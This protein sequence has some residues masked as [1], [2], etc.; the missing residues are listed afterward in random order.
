MKNKMIS[1]TAKTLERTNIS[2]EIMS[3]V[4]QMNILIVEDEHQLR[5]L[6]AVILSDHK[7]KTAKNGQEGL[8]MFKA[9]NFDVVITD[10]D[11]PIMDGM[12][13]LATIKKERPSTRVIIM[14]GGIDE[15]RLEAIKLL[16]PEEIYAKPLDLFDLREAIDRF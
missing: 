13:L 4:R 1:L 11:M 14:S 12:K 16:K 6:L 15:T 7:C 5:E 10:L 2:G 8:E 9:G 3:S